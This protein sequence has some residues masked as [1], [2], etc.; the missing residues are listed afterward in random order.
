MG[1]LS[2]YINEV[3]LYLFDRGEA[4]RAY[5]TFGCHRVPDMADAHIFTVW[6]PNAESVSLVGDFNGWDQEA[7]PM[8]DIHNG[9]WSCIVCGLHDGDVYKYAITDKRGD[10][11][12]K[13]DPFA[14][15]AENGLSTASKVWD[16]KGYEWRDGGYMQ[17]R[18]GRNPQREA[19]SIYE[20]HLGSWRLPEGGGLPNYRNV[21]DEL[22][23]YCK[24]M[25][26][27]HVEPMPLNEYPLPA[28]WGYQTTGYYAITSR[29][30]TPQ[31][32]M[33][34]V[35]TLHEAGIGV[36]MD[37]VPAH[38][39]RDSFALAQF[40]GT[41]LFEYADPRKGEHEEWGTLVFDYGRPQVISFLVSA[42]MFL[43]DVYHIDGLRVDAV[44]SMLYLD[45]GRTDWV[46]NKDGGNINYEAV[47]FL[48][49]LN[50]SVLESYPG[51]A[52]IAEEST[53]YPMVTMPPYAGGLGFTFKW[54]MG[55]M[56]DVLDYSQT[57]PLFRSGN[58]H[59]LTFSMDYAYSESYILE[60]SHD[61]VV[62]GK[63]SMIDKMHGDYD[64]KFATYRAILG[65][66]FAHPGKKLTFM[67]SEFA[68]F[69]EWDF[70]REIEWGMLDY[71][72][73]S[74]MQAYCAALNR[75]YASHAA[76]W[77]DDMDPKG[78][79]WANRNNRDED[80]LAFLRLVASSGLE[81][82]SLNKSEILCCFNYSPNPIVG[83]R[84]GLPHACVLAEVLNSDDAEFGGC[85]RRNASYIHAEHIG[86]EGQPYSA[87]INVAPLSCVYFECIH[88]SRGEQAMS[89]H[90]EC[91]AMILAGGQGSRLGVLTRNRAKPAV[92]YGGKYRIIDF[93]LSN[94]ANSGLEVIGVLT[95]YEPFVLNS[96]IGTG[97]P[98]DLDSPAGG[99]FVLS[100]YTR[101][102]D[103]GNWY[104]GTAN[105]V[106]QNIDFVD[107]YSPE[108]LVVLSGDHIYKMDYSKMVRFHRNHEADVTIAARKVPISEASR[109]GIL[110][111]SGER[112][113]D[114]VE[115]PDV[116]PN[117]L[118]SMGVYVFNWE[119]L[120]GYLQAD[121]MNADS[122][123]DFGKDIIPAM[124]GSG[125][126]IYAYSFNGYWR[127][128]GT[129]TSLWE[130]NMGLL[131]DDPNIDLFDRAWRIYSRNP[132]M[133]AAY[134]GDD[135]RLETCM[136]PEGCEIYGEVNRSVLFQGV[137]VAADAQVQD[138]VIMQS[139]DIGPGAK[140]SRTVMAENV[141]VGAGARIGGS[142]DAALVVIGEGANIAPG[143]VVEEGASIEPG[144]IYAQKGDGNE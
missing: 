25:G 115:K 65:Y 47:A 60:F 29:Y 49:K 109:F 92:P 31:D 96:Y 133:P 90:Q 36:I 21:A 107:R 127:D 78:F 46:R 67:G 77:L 14:Y 45:Y 89:D 118:A 124:L 87:T 23:E 48:Q 144:A 86:F 54:N 138:S 112:V 110:D 83:L 34:L 94:C 103:V 9:I 58:H 73:H 126:S 30:G 19:M 55:F 38:F 122:S 129:V 134:I 135:A 18:A 68:Q 62:Y 136:V 79:I 10:T 141:V 116:P 8:Q 104:S 43:F 4:T 50:S 2:K 57:D 117:D 11:H 7:D 128:V 143:A 119:K 132:F 113:V 80:A 120:K 70:E 52:M 137:K 15:H 125:E 1:D 42:A 76:F 37:W 121:A 106:Y 85:A 51:T 35:D 63:K 97:A 81:D 98:W 33:Y 24:K 12:L 131:D 28:S 105:A 40:D 102:G 108:Y 20:F 32:F 111:T 114:F 139:S 39:P 17:G 41:P 27:T 13:A 99:V 61:E 130:A 74:Q 88:D 6:A 95:Q 22:V 72:A 142:G 69:S 101:S 66:Q 16:L 5:L 75:F 71:E 53:A 123:H 59:K 26:Y 100:P 84:V 93:T 91:M 64:R 140:V 3:D 82:A 44:S 56:H